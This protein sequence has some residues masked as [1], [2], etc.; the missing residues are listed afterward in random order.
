MHQKMLQGMNLGP[1]PAW[2]FFFFFLICNLLTSCPQGDLATA[3][4]RHST[5][6]IKTMISHMKMIRGPQS[7]GIP[8]YN[9]KND[10]T[11]IINLLRSIGVCLQVSA[12]TILEVQAGSYGYSSTSS[13]GVP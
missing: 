5:D 11:I 13:L 2:Y 9:D 1:P 7:S 6:E 4:W 10:I 3:Q 12:S 8:F